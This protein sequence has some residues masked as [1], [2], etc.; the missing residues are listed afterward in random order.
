MV[1]WYSRC[2][3]SVGRGHMH[4]Q[5]VTPACNSM[6]GVFV[7]S[8]H[9]EK[10]G[11][12]YGHGSDPESEEAGRVSKVAQLFFIIAAASKDHHGQPL[13]RSECRLTAR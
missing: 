4:Q 11:T 6:T 3:S 2:M 9:M 8:W 7:V 13:S 5:N 10:K 1:H 12:R